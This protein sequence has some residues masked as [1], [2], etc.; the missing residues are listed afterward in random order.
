MLLYNCRTAFPTGAATF[1]NT[2]ILTMLSLPAHM[3]RRV[4]SFLYGT[5]LGSAQSSFLKAIVNRVFF[6]IFLMCVSRFVILPGKK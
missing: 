6:L 4:S 5:L 2:A 1:G 3:H